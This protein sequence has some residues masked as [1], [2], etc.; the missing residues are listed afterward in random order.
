MINIAACCGED[1]AIAGGDIVAMCKK[2]SKLMTQVSEKECGDKM[3]ALQTSDLV[4]F[5]QTMLCV[6]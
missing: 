1:K 2:T 6:S 3:R 5:N 4:K